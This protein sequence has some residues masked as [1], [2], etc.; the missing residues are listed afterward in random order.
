MARRILKYYGNEK[1]KCALPAGPD[2]AQRK[3]SVDLERRCQDTSREI[4]T[5]NKRQD[6]FQNA[7]EGK[8]RVQDT[9]SERM[10]NQNIEEIK[11]F[12]H[13]KKKPCS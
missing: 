4:Q 5:L 11:E 1:K 12:V 9:A 8:P 3:G 7:I 13:T 6:I 10:Q 2:E